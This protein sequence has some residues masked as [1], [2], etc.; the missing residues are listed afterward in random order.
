M[1]ERELP[2]IGVVIADDHPIVR[3]GIATQ[4]SYHDDIKVCGQAPNGQ[5]ALDLVRQHQ[6]QV[7]VLDMHMPGMRSLD[8]LEQVRTLPAPPRVLILTAH[9]DIESVL[10]LLKAG[11]KGYLLKDEEPDAITVAVRAVAEGKTW[12]S[13]AIT[14]SM[15][16]HSTR[17][18]PKVDKPD[19][20]TR[21][22]EVLRL[23]ADGQ[24]NHEIGDKLGIS[25][26]TVRFH[27]RNIYDK[28]GVQRRG[29]AIAWAV[30]QYLGESES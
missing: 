29:P 7:L 28:L 23:L 8:V 13:A 17:E 24:D 1:L 12:L 15:V 30:R 14:A 5:G 4:L 21:E 10:S 26:R 22:I 25:E 18:T 19:L 6:P 27:L 2:K 9:S 11:A 20:S 3:A 16:E